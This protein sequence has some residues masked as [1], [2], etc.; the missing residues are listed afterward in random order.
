MAPNGPESPMERPPLGFPKANGCNKT[1]QP[2]LAARVL[3]LMNVNLVL[4]HISLRRG[5]R[6]PAKQF[7]HVTKSC[8]SVC[9]HSRVNSKHGE[10]VLAR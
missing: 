4:L 7:N 10:A 9:A 8:D 5:A 1:T 3:V 6:K 2:N